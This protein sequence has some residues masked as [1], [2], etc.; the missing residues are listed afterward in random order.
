[1]GATAIGG[2]GCQPLDALYYKL[3]ALIVLFPWV[4]VGLTAAGFLWNRWRRNT[5]TA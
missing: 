1:M 2:A 4:L 5:G 3:I